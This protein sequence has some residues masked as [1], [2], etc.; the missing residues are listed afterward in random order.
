MV[1]DGYPNLSSQKLDKEEISVIFSKEE[2][3]DNRI[4]KILE[5]QGNP[6]NT[7]VVSDDKEIRFFVRA[8]GARSIGVEEF[9]H[10]A[11]IY[12]ARINHKEKSGRALQERDLLKPE[13]SY[14]QIDQ[15]NR[16][17]KARWLKD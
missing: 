15:I 13:L 12:R 9:I 8:V 7:V 10:P 1:F 2:T 3:A 6:K 14:S 5:T 11:T 17:L 4:K 16:E